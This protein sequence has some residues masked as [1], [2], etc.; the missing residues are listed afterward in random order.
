[1][2]NE[3]ATGSETK[4]RYTP[5]KLRSADNGQGISCHGPGIPSA[6]SKPSHDAAPKHGCLMRFIVLSE[7]RRRPLRGVLRLS[8]RLRLVHGKSDN[9]ALAQPISHGNRLQL[10]GIPTVGGPSLP[11]LSYIGGV[12]FL[13]N[14]PAIVNEGSARVR[15][16]LLEFTPS[17]LRHEE[18]VQGRRVQARSAGRMDYCA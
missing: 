7:L 18:I 5:I 6:W 4:Q 2:Y 12:R 16:E 11:L 8:L 3:R 15:Q 13:L 10:S 17:R 9:H 14:G 1:M